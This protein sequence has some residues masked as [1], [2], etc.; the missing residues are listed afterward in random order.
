MPPALAVDARAGAR[1]LFE[2]GPEGLRER[3]VPRLLSVETP[4]R[5]A[6]PLLGALRAT[7]PE[8]PGDA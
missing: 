2:A 4:P 6:A 1:I 7:N 5:E 3:L 8:R